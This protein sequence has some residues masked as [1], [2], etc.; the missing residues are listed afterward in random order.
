MPWKTVYAYAF[1]EAAGSSLGVRTRNHPRCTL[2]LMSSP[3]NMYT[4]SA[5]PLEELNPPEQPRRRAGL[6]VIVVDVLQE[7]QKYS[8]GDGGAGTD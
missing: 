1:S 8:A 7:T 2:V 4:K 5:A 6:N 3:G